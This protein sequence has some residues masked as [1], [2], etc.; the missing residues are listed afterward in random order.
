MSDPIRAIRSADRDELVRMRL[1]LWPDSEVF[2]AD[3]VLGRSGSGFVVLVAERPDGGLCGFAEIGS[4]PFAEGCQ[5]SPVAYLEGI[6][7]DPDARRCSVALN[8][9]GHAEKWARSK[10][11]TELASDCDIDNVGSQAFHAAAGFTEV[12]RNVC[13]RRDLA[14]EAAT[15][16]TWRALVQT[17]PR[18]PEP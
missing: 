10:G 1:C 5:S 17:D 4:R 15:D 2:E 13:F 18:Y 9:V 3:S 14:S 16:L 12:Q 11:F 7:V 6:W 8:L